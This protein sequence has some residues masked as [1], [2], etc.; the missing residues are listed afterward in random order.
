MDAE[1]RNRRQGIPL[2]A[3]VVSDLEGLGSRVGLPFGC[4]PCLPEDA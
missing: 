3:V 2:P 4:Q 1:A